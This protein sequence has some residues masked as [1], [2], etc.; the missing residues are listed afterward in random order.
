LG[1]AESGEDA[2]A[3]DV[4]PATVTACSDARVSMVKE[5]VSSA[6]A[7]ALGQQMLPIKSGRRSKDDLLD[8]RIQGL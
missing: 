3:I 6:L 5:R 2:G 1:R 8:T 7:L 4:R